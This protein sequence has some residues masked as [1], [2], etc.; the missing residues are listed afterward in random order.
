VT[1]A[2][3]GC[4]RSAPAPSAP[5]SGG[6]EL[7]RLGLDELLARTRAEPGERAVLLNF[8]ATW[9]GPCMAEMP[10]LER[11]HAEYAGRG[12][13]VLA[14]S[15][16]VA[17][18]QGEIDEPAEVDAFAARRGLELPLAVYTGSLD[19]Y[20]QGVVE[21]FDL[22]GAVLPTTLVFAPGGELVVK[23]IG[24][25]KLDEFV[26]LLREAVPELE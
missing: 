17:I 10:E 26:A 15:M 13:R 14:V 5:G 9:C 3:A 4:G 18:P 20:V 16:D 12:V 19:E 25:A 6:G 24:G 1:L 2:L 22:D 11:L 7:A 8:W 21:R 23:H